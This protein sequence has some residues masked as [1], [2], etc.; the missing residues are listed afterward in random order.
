MNYQY[1]LAKWADRRKDIHCPN[2]GKGHG[3]YKEYVDG[4][5]NPVDPDNH[6]CGKCDHENSCGY[7]VTPKQWQ[8]E[9]GKI[10]TSAYT[11]IVYKKKD[12]LTIDPAIVSRTIQKNAYTRNTLVVWL[13]SLP[14]NSAQKETL[15]QALQLYCVGT[16][17]NGSVIFWQIDQDRKV[18]TGKKMMYTV[19]GKRL[20]NAKGESIGFGFMHNIVPEAK[21]L[22]DADTHEY[23]QCAFGLH[24][25]RVF[26]DAEVHIVESEKTALLMTCYDQTPWHEHVWI[27]VGSMQQLSEQWLQG[28][29]GR[30]LVAYPD[31]NAVDDW[32]RRADMLKATG[33]TINLSTAWMQHYDIQADPKADIGDLVLQRLLMTPEAIREEMIER[34]PI[35]Q[36]LID[37][38]QLTL[39][40]GNESPCG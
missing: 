16:M 34:F 27:A 19:E 12:M 32:T 5:G 6:L 25:T 18:R 11:P 22:L 1:H 39:I 13:H 29:K 4:N 23:R 10:D 28:L 30:I 26:P 3:C 8:Q 33:W 15:E 20:K 2:C 14:W 36:E 31:A 17:R 21:A 40:N 38:L 7:H 37:K 9:H 35:T 24:L